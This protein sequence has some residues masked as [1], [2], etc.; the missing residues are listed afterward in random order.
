M[1]KYVVTMSH[2]DGN[3]D[4][5]VRTCPDAMQAANYLVAPGWH[6]TSVVE[7]KEPEP[8]KQW[9]ISRWRIGNMAFR[10]RSD[11][12]K[13]YLYDTTTLCVTDDVN[14]RSCLWSSKNSDDLLLLATRMANGE[15]NAHT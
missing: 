12:T 11:G 5:V 15:D 3:T 10:I 14:P 9:T 13:F 4:S 7:V 6:I 1:P 8:P 2:Y